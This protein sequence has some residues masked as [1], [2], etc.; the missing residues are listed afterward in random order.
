MAR[1]PFEGGSNHFR[2]RHVFHR[3]FL[4]EFRPLARPLQLVEHRFGSASLIE[5]LL[6]GGI[7][8][9]GSAVGDLQFP[10]PEAE[11]VELLF[12]LDVAAVA[13]L[14]SL[15]VFFGHPEGDPTFL[16]MRLLQRFVSGWT[17]EQLLAVPVER[18]E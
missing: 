6:A 11:A 4:G 2:Y 3:E 17:R 18:R 1:Q 7:T 12:L 14:A 15:A 10:L 13:V 8:Q 9:P 16:A 5:E